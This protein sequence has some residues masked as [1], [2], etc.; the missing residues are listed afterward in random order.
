MLRMT[1]FVTLALVGAL[2]IGPAMAAPQFGG[3]NDAPGTGS[4]H[5]VDCSDFQYRSMPFCQMINNEPVGKSAPA[6]TDA[7]RLNSLNCPAKALVPAGVDGN[8]T[9]LYRC[10]TQPGTN[11]NSRAMTFSPGY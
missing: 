9:R 5:T 6:R 7:R 4:D 2:A 1:V 10:S 8:G 11:R 3:T